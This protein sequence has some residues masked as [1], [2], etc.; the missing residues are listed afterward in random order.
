[1]TA[2]GPLPTHVLLA[3]AANYWLRYDETTGM[4]LITGPVTEMTAHA[5]ADGT[6]YYRDA[7]VPVPAGAFAAA[8]LILNTLI[9][10]RTVLL[11]HRA[12]LPRRDD[13]G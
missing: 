7:T 2:P 5:T 1:M 11:V 10:D 6:G 8:A 3:A 13:F 4:V 12:E 9:R